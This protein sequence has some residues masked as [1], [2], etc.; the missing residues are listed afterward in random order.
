[1]DGGPLPI[2]VQRARMAAQWPGFRFGNIGEPGRTA[3]W[4]GEVRPQFTRFTIELRYRLLE[5]PEVRVLRPTLVR[6]PENPEGKLPHVYPPADDPV[7]CLFDPAANEWDASMY[8][9]ET[10]I[11]WSLDWLACYEFWLMTGRWTGGG[12]HGSQMP[13]L[14]SLT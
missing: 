11:P 1:M 12:R 6:L 13:S 7:L 10:T 9:A 5:V 2:A 8:L 4:V 3:R 14:G